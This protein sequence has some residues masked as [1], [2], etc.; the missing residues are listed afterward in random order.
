MKIEHA[1]YQIED[2]VATAAWY[3]KHLGMTVK[4]AQTDWLVEKAT[5]L[6]VSPLEPRP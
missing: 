1:A 2:P 5:E 4:R 3:V 6:G